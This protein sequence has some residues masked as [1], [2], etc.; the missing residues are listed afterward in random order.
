MQRARRWRA[1]F[2][3]RGALPILCLTA[4]LTGAP[5]QA[6]TPWT[7]VDLPESCQSPDHVHGRATVAHVFDGDTVR[8]DDGTRVRLIGLDTPEYHHRNPDLDPEP[9]AEEAHDALSALLAYHGHQVIVVHDR[10]LHDRFQRLLAHLF[11]PDGQSVTALM[12][13]QGLATRLTI[14]P[15]DWNLDCYRDA[16]RRAGEAR[17]GLWALPEH[18]LFDARELPR[19]AEGFRRVEGRVVRIGESSR[20]VWIN[21]EGD[22]AL[23]VDHPDLANFP[24]LDVRALENQRVRARGHVYNHRGQPRIR[25]RHPA[26]LEVLEP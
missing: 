15:N 20:A 4:L 22:V 9:F 14:P 1:L 13:A 25:I 2:L 3:V 24:E 21:L 18:R 8:L 16:E 10:E 7:P 19:D 6:Q 5:A 26:N 12:L 17:L 23:R 11:T